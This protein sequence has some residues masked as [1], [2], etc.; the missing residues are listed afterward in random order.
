M[1][2]TA[3]TSSPTPPQKLYKF[4]AIETKEDWRRLRSILLKYELYCPSPISFNDP[5]D[6]R[7]PPLGDIEPV[8]ARYLICPSNQSQSTE[9]LTPSE[10]CE[11]RQTL[12][13]AQERINS[14]GVLSLAASR[15][16]TLMW[17]HYARDHRG[18]AL[19][20]DTTEWCSHMPYMAQ[21]FF[22]VLYSEQRINLNL[23]RR[24]YDNAQFFKSTILTKDHCWESEQEWRIIQSKP[25]PLKFPPSALTGIIFGCRTP[26]RKKMKLRKM[27]KKLSGVTWHQSETRMKQFGLDIKQY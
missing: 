1:D 12:A 8:F 22:P 26:E 19:E 13:K 4:R 9:P 14:S 3:P 15:D 17:S 18:I 20:F 27:C 7:T 21:H 23:T 11:L 10:N 2:Q 24:E 16:S 5:F 6:C 25:S